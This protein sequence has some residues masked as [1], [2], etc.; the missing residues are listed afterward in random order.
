MGKFV[1]GRFRADRHKPG[2]DA[3]PDPEPRDDAWLRLCAL[4]GK[5]GTFRWGNKRTKQISILW[6]GKWPALIRVKQ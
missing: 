5:L 3:D 4:A 6:G 2:W 1:N